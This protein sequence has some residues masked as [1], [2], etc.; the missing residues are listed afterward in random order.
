MK[1]TT[2]IKG[3]LFFL[4]IIVV[5]LSACSSAQDSPEV[6]AKS[7]VASLKKNSS[8]DFLKLILD[9]NDILEIFSL[10]SDNNMDNKDILEKF[11]KESEQM[12][13][14]IRKEAV[15]TFDR[16]RKKAT[17]DGLDWNLAKIEKIE[18][19]TKQQD[20]IPFTSISIYLRSGENLYLL[21]V[22]D[23]YKTK[24]GWIIADRPR[25]KGKQEQQ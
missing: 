11:E 5:S 8:D 6:L 23:T 7:F 9:K 1:F 10:M 4:C 19:E 24:R 3:I 13:A 21:Q 15:E 14:G 2:G 20:D 12:V 25:W 22:R 18:K 17:E 16:I